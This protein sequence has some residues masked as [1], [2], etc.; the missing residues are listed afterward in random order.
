MC[1]CFDY[2]YNQYIYYVKGFHVKNESGREKS[3]TIANDFY[4]NLFFNCMYT[5]TVQTVNSFKY[6][7]LNTI[8]NMFLK[9]YFTVNTNG[10]LW[11]I[12]ITRDT[13]ETP[14]YS[15]KL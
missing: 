6:K 9:L 10:I 1:Q 3:T 5:I 8:V 11:V 13:W 4:V 7:L 15:M 2:S 14:L 12:P